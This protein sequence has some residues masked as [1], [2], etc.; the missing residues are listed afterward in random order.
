VIVPQLWLTTRSC[1]PVAIPST[2]RNRKSEPVAALTFYDIVCLGLL[3]LAFEKRIMQLALRAHGRYCY[4]VRED[5][6][7]T[8]FSARVVS[9]NRA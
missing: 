6:I 9:D 7:N 1:K 5:L 4:V 2:F 8:G 3:V